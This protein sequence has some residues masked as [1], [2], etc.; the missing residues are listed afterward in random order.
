MNPQFLSI[1]YIFYQVYL[2]FVWVGDKLYGAP[3]PEATTVTTPSAS[4]SG[5]ATT[6]LTIVEV[7]VGILV[8]TL[9]G[10]VYWSILRWREEIKKREKKYTDA[11][12]PISV[13]TPQYKNPKWATVLMRLDSDSE[14]EWRLAILEADNML[15]DLLAS[16]N[17]PG[18]TLGERLTNANAKT[19]KTLQG[20]W[21]AHKVRNSIA[22]EGSDFSLTAREAKRVIGLFEETF[23]EFNYI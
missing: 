15:G 20:A 23:K 10:M 1:D 9:V 16:R 7:I 13:T 2:F 3:S 5:V 22:H 8:L 12:K 14:T 18:S 21:D 11:H 4:V 17:I 19:F 6:F